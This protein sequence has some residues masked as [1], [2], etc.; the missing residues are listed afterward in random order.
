M[1]WFD[2]EIDLA[3]NQGVSHP[4]NLPFLLLPETPNGRAVLLIHGF[5]ASP[6]ELRPLGEILLRHNFTVYGIRLEGH[7]TNPA[8]LAR[9]KAEEWLAT[10][11]RGYQSLAEMNLRV[12]AAGL[13][14]GALLALQL[15][16]THPLEKLILLSPFLK[17]RHFL[18]PFAG[19]LSVLIP[20]QNRGI[21]A[22]EQPFY[23]R[24][25]PLKGVA[26]INRLRRRISRRLHRLTT[27]TLV[28]AS[29][30][31]VTVAPGTAEALFKKLG[32]DSKQFHCYGPEVPHVLTT[33]ENPLQQDVLQRCVNFLASPVDRSPASDS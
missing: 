22:A 20:Y 32:S 31:D 23:Y 3:H 29:A 27:P 24:Q 16:L 8:D 12:S 9:R 4:E 7:G 10:V 26:Q 30:G 5:T 15:A 17:L 19:P 28:L 33:A 2:R 25:R 18:A 11:E 13:S 14:T 21:P 1:R 6:R